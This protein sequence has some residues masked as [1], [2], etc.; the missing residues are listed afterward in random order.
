MKKT[1]PLNYLTDCTVCEVIQVDSFWLSR[2]VF[3]CWAE[4]ELYTVPKSAQLRA[5]SHGLAIT[6]EGFRLLPATGQVYMGTPA[7]LSCNVEFSY[8]CTPL[9]PR[10]TLAHP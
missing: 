7:P 5:A 4:P 9:I 6:L 10:R 1:S 8:V 2:A 3:L